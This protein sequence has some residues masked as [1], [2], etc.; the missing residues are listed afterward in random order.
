[1]AQRQ[2]RDVHDSSD[3]GSSE[4]ESDSDED[5]GFRSKREKRR[6]AEKQAKK[7]KESKKKKS[8]KKKSHKQSRRLATGSSSESSD[9]DG[10]PSPPPP[11]EK[12]QLSTLA[13]DD[14]MAMSF[15]P[16]APEAAPVE[17]PKTEEELLEEARAKRIQDEID[18]GLRE[19]VTGMLFGFYDPKQP[20]AYRQEATVEE[21]KD[22]EDADPLIGDGGASWR[23]KMLQRAR[24]KARET[25]RPL[26]EI[27]LER[28]GS[29]DVLKQAARS[30]AH[31]NAHLHYKRPERREGAEREDRE[32]SEE[33]G[34]R[35]LGVGRDASDR[36]LLAKFSSRVQ[37][38][39]S[40]T[41]GRGED[42]ER[43]RTGKR[44]RRRDEEDDDDE[45]PID[46]SKLPD[47]ENR[48][49]AKYRAA[50]GDTKRSRQ[51]SRRRSRSRSRERRSD[52]RSRSRERSSA[53]KRPRRSR[54]RSRSPA[55]QA[56]KPVLPQATKPVPPAPSQPR[57]PTAAEV[58]KQAMERA[59]LEKR[60]AFLY[61]RKAAASEAPPLSSP[62]AVE[63]SSTSKQETTEDVDLNKL[64]ARALRA[65][66]MG[67]TDLFRK[68]TDQL[69]EL[70][71]HRDAAQQAASVPHYD[72]VSGALPPL[73]KEDLRY[74]PRKGKKNPRDSKDETMSLE[75]LVRQERMARVDHD[76][77][78]A[79]HARNI[80]RLGTKYRGTEVNARNLASGFD[81]E[82]QVDMTLLARPETKLTARAAA[83]RE[84]ARAVGASKKWEEKT[85]KCVACLQSPLF[86]K[87]LMLALGEHMY[88]A[89]PT[90][91]RL[92][93]AHCLIV[94]M[95]HTA[96]LTGANEQVWQ[97][98]RKFQRA[99]AR[100]CDAMF[101][102]GVVF[103]EQTSAPSRRRHTF[104]EC[105]PVPKDVAADTPLY[106]KQE[107]MQADEEW[108]THKKIIDTRD[109]G[110]TR[111]VPPQF[112]YFHIEWPALDGESGGGGYAH[113]IEDEEQFPRDFG[114]NVVAGMLGV[115]PP[116]YGRRGDDRK[117][118][119][120]DE[121]KDVLEFLRDWEGFDWTQE[122]D[123]GEYAQ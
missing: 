12:Q 68:L 6:R 97:E 55:K 58:E 96:S 35:T 111:H 90:K 83:E 84:R 62:H 11:Q 5:D 24:D 44:D 92:H 4:S 91:P 107:L 118:S 23:A 59:E 17:V 70:E 50:D 95:D 31:L 63:K 87:H 45:M 53:Y 101:D 104:M 16:R 78:D 103:L 64:A 34:R 52:R 119:F 79:T 89:M 42:D 82:D 43:N 20:D 21:A 85:Q 112:A 13:R 3:S 72:A 66:M 74:G 51:A 121:K 120:D 40:R 46:Y 81:E 99:V 39:V 18:A 60:N 110:V 109:G 76:T 32:D 19:P 123:G 29:L 93:R 80:V 106:F 25:G 65:Q 1:M 102:M 9:S 38:S 41:V 57:E 61:G 22:D 122:L 30:S 15:E 37:S 33:R 75:E 56:V 71:A 67:N 114:V 10:A 7:R 113:V 86:K 47:F 69:N 28:F 117:R 100:M 27:V 88:L 77:M 115:D 36:N 108:A 26:D 94:P 105:I 116:K 48:P 54:S 49:G 2:Q 73:E 8:K 98:V 14:W